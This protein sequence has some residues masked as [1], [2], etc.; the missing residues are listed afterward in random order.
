MNA[1][2]S[3]LINPLAEPPISSPGDVEI[4]HAVCQKQG[5]DF[6]LG[7]YFF[8]RDKHGNPFRGMGDGEAAT[9]QVIVCRKCGGSQ[10]VQMG[11]KKDMRHP[12]LPPPAP[13]VKTK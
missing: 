11:P 7:A 12:K 2:A 13:A 3:K 6:V 8:H 10:E 5:H 1:T 9:F 4:A